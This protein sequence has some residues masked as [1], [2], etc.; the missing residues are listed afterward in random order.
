METVPVVGK[1]IAPHKFNSVDFPQPLRPVSAIH[2][3]GSAE[4]ETPFRAVTLA[5]FDG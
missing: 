1:S 5:P 4:K 2:S 3:P